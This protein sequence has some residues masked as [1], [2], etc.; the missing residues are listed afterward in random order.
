MKFTM[1]LYPEIF[2]G[3]TI[4]YLKAYQRYTAVKVITVKFH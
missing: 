2:V 1:F 4:Y 3:H